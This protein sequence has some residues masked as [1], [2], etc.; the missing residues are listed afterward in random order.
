MDVL[1]QILDHIH[2]TPG[3]A[4]LSPYQILFGKERTLAGVPYEPPVECEVAKAFFERQKVVDRAVAKLLNEKHL[5]KE[6]WV[7]QKRVQPPP[8]KLETL[9]GISIPPTVV[10]SLQADG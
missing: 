5:K 8:S 3:D 7:N 6:G 2:D 1:P 4:G 9:C 10:T